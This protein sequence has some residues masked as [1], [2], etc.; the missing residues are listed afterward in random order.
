MNNFL[1]QSQPL[2]KIHS[3]TQEMKINGRN[4]EDTY[5]I[6]KREGAHHDFDE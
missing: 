3:L 2:S 6:H 4:E 1:T 5:K